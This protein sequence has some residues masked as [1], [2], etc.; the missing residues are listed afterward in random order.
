MGQ[1]MYQELPE[2]LAV[3]FFNEFKGLPRKLHVAGGQH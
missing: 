3:K 1:I 2:E